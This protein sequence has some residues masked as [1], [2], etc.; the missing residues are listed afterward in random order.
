MST[1]GNNDL[2]FRAMLFGQ[3]ILL[4]WAV[5]FVYRWRSSAGNGRGKLRLLFQVFL[6]TGVLGTIY[7]VAELRVFTVLADDG[8]Y[9]DD[10]PWL[11]DSDELAVDLYRVRSGFEE[12][13]RKLPP[14]AIIQYNPDNTA[15]VPNIYYGWRQSVEGLQ[16]CG[17]PFGGDPFSCLPYQKKIFEAFIGRS[18]YS[19]E[20]ANQLCDDLGIDLLIAE[21]PDRMWA[22]KE[23]WVWSG[24]PVVDNEYMRA[25][26]CGRRRDEIARSFRIQP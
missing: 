8:R 1:T 14:D 9:I 17:T 22:V 26:P 21:R 13:N 19:L 3:F 24:T 20:Q 25:I 4:L 11:P 7:Q 5:P 10:A 18:A 2:G 15:Y 16:V 23:S 12:I 6:W